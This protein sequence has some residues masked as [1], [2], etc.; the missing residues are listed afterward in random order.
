MTKERNYFASFSL[1]MIIVIAAAFA[2]VFYAETTGN[3]GYQNQAEPPVQS[4]KDT[5]A[6]SI[7]TVNYYLPKEKTIRISEEEYVRFSQQ[8]SVPV[9]G[10]ARYQWK[11]NGIVQSQQ[12]DFVF[13]GKTYDKGNHKVSVEV[14]DNNQRAIAEWIVAVNEVVRARQQSNPESRVITPGCSATC[15]NDQIECNEECDGN[16]N[17]ACGGSRCLSDCTCQQAQSV[18]CSENWVCTPFSECDDGFKRRSCSDQNSCGSTQNKP[19][20]QIACQN[21]QQQSEERASPSGSRALTWIIL[22]LILV[23]FAAITITKFAKM[24]TITG[25]EEVSQ[26][27]VS[28]QSKLSEM[29][30]WYKNHGMDSAATYSMLQRMGF[31]KQ[32]AY[33]ATQQA[34][35][36]KK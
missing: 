12:K 32:E 4:Q 21:A 13:M 27:T 36:Q 35:S 31:S 7:P 5:Q 1:A 11:V 26:D 16:R 33:Q 8:D 10:S 28:T 15:G 19:N 9:S 23:P 34:F 6:G 24:R 30:Q 14:L 20:T 2:T 29:V 25:Q 3:A 17:F 18:A 22:G